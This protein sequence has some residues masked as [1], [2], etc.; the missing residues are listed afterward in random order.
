M[1]F[2]SPKFSTWESLTL[3]AQEWLKS[4]LGTDLVVACGT[5]HVRQVFYCHKLMLRNM[6]MAECGNDVIFSEEETLLLLPDTDPVQFSQF[7]E[8]SYGFRQGS[9]K[10]VETCAF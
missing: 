2:T 9:I 8:H 1:K 3:V 4:G 10:L 5:K 7:L 6:I